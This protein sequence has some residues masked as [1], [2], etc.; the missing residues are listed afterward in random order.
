M[1]QDGRM[2]SAKQDEDFCVGVV[3]VRTD[4]QAPWVWIRARA[5]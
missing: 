1:T 5:K 3:C 4:V 2:L